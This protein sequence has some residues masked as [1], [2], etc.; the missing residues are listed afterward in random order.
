MAY[1]RIFNV[2]IA[3]SGDAAEERQSAFEAISEWNGRLAREIVF[4]P[5][6]WERHAISD[7]DSQGP[8]D[9][10]N[11]QLLD[12]SDFVIAIFRG[13]IGTPTHRYPGGTVEELA[14]RKGKAAVF[15]CEPLP[16]LD[17][18]RPDL[19]DAVQQLNLLKEFKKRFNSPD[20]GFSRVYKDS[21]D[22]AVKVRNQLEG[23]AAEIDKRPEWLLVRR[24]GPLSFD[25]L[26]EHAEAPEEDRCLLIYNT[27]LN[28]FK[29]IESF[30]RTWSFLHDP[31]KRCIRRV[32]FLLP[33]FK[34]NR[35]RKYVAG[36]RDA[37]EQAY[38]GILGR[39][40]VCQV[41]EE[42]SAAPS[43]ASSSLAFVLV[44]RGSDPGA[45]EFLPQAYLVPLCEPFAW[46]PGYSGREIDLIWEYR[47]FLENRD[48][49]FSGELQD[50]W[51]KYYNP[52][53][54]V[55]VT[56]FTGA[57]AVTAEIDK[58]LEEQIVRHGPNS[59]QDTA[60][61][62]L[63]AQLRGCLFDPN[64]PSY[65][66]NDAFEIL[67]WNAAFELIFPT[68]RFYRNQLAKAFV[69]VLD[70]APEVKEEARRIVQSGQGN[71]TG[72]LLEQLAFSSPV[73]GN[74]AF[75]KIASEFV[76]EDSRGW[77]VALNINQVE[78]RGQYEADLRR[79]NRE[80]ALITAFM[81][82]FDRF[83]TEFPGLSAI[84]NAF[85]TEVLGTCSKVLDLGAGTGLL[86]E[87]MLREGKSVT[88]VETSDVLLD[89]LRKRCREL[90]RLSI[91]KANIESLHAPPPF[92]DNAKIGINP[93]YDAACIHLH[94]HWLERPVEFLKRLVADELIVEGGLVAI[95]LISSG[96]DFEAYFRALQQFRA[97]HPANPANNGF[98]DYLKSVAELL[99]LGIV[100]KYKDAEV[101]KHLADAGYELLSKSST[102]FQVAGRNYR[103][104]PLLVAR[105]PKP[106]GG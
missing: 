4:V 42:P 43:R 94:Y 44:R 13:R 36:L 53:R 26:C 40:S 56:D 73:Y 14:E 76:F 37:V 69:D 46:A 22:L 87:V 82:G 10:I 55:P 12:R 39:F 57:K 101:E 15:F 60:T 100:G 65:L 75:T 58:V 96:K 99:E 16:S 70:N 38:P 85:R 23:W 86:T 11:Q 18:N 19:E 28:A 48:P 33:E 105:A 81:Q 25:S 106:G 88:A 68:D 61:L 27:E 74:M 3:S 89:A 97:N 7:A 47:C 45:G 24:P 84:Q 59:H 93:P 8:Q 17:A 62:A 54:S 77:I 35:L 92:Y 6:M 32:V 72:L 66:L 30:G 21:S 1:A 50:I 102:G 51:G 5:L 63:I 103:G 90:A 91:L 9:A 98:Q 29:D 80:Q 20:G 67:D 83:Q 31:G 71:E 49:V 34:I 52:E 79:I 64:V 2:L 95:L 104:F 41:L 78:H